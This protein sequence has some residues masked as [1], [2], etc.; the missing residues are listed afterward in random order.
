M[1]TSSQNS[2]FYHDMG[3]GTGRRHPLHDRVSTV[4][5]ISAIHRLEG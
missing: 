3:D 4:K 1:A 5:G 2:E